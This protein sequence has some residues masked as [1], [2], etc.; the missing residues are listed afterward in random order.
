MYEYPK[1]TPLM[2]LFS[3]KVDGLERGCSV[4]VTRHSDLAEKKFFLIAGVKNH[5]EYFMSSITDVQAAEYFPK[6]KRK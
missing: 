4:T 2:T 3:F 5:L 1:T 6:E